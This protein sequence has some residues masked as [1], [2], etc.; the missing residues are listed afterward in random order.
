MKKIWR[1]IAAAA[2]AAVLALSAVPAGRVSADETAEEQTA[3]EQD[4]AETTDGETA[5]ESGTAA[6]DTGSGVQTIN[7]GDSSTQSSGSA[8]AG[9]EAKETYGDDAYIFANTLQTNYPVRS[10]N[11]ANLDSARD[12]LVQTVQTLGFVP[13]VQHFEYPVPEKGWNLI[14]DNIIFSKQ[15]STDSSKVIIVGAHYDSV[16]TNGADDNASGVGVLLELAN[17]V[18]AGTYPYTIRFVLFSAEEPGVYGS[19]Y[20]VENLSEE[21][22]NSILCMINLDTIGAGDYTYLYGGDVDDSG[23]FV[24]TWLV[25]QAL[26]DAEVLGLE[27]STHPDVNPQ[28]PAPTK[29]TASD[30]Q[31]FNEIGIP[32]L[33]CEASNWNGG[34]YDNFYQTSN[35]AV[36]N[37]KIMHVAAY[38]NLD[39]INSTFG[40]RYAQ[41]LEDYCYL[42]DYLLHNITPDSSVA[43][44]GTETDETV[45]V[46]PA[47]ELVQATENVNI[48]STPS[49]SG[50]VLGML[51]AGSEI[52]RTGTV[53]GWSQVDYNGTAAYIKSEYLQPAEAESGS[54][55]ETDAEEETGLEE[56]TEAETDPEGE[57]SPEEETDTETETSSEAET[58][59]DESGEDSAE[60][61]SSGEAVTQVSDRT[62]GTADSSAGSEGSSSGSSDS[63]GTSGTAAA[64]SSQTASS[65]PSVTSSSVSGT[66]VTAADTQKTGVIDSF[67]SWLQ[68]SSEAKY[69]AAGVVVLLAVILCLVVFLIRQ[70]RK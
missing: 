40:N 19:R 33:Y 24:R 25:E 62:A 9:L 53:D 12:W 41:H 1:T 65:Q 13:S 36:E 20:Y 31:F 11:T 30:Q 7:L 38:D 68:G 44:A 26:A 23:N 48:R 18:S 70:L 22:R 42:L 66:G 57:N 6:D 28:Y 67:V 43:S 69:A 54:E 52:R 21:D 32:Y 55:E 35:P 46:E 8:A 14:G 59:S 3:G 60:E 61:T 37:G 16:G 63:S 2:A 15:G 4:G 10:M 50:E 5:D 51:E 56:E 27:M 49:V 58:D 34:N 39:F 47:D 17:C 45:Q 64:S 29:T